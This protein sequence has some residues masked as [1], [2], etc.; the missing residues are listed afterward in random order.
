[1][2]KKTF[3]WLPIII[4]VAMVAGLYIGRY[5]HQASMIGP[6]F[7]STHSKIESLLDII[8]SQY[9]D[10]VDS[11]Q[12]VEDVMPKIIGELD[13]HSA[14]IPAKDLESVN[15]EL[16]GS[17]GGIGVQFSI[18]ND[19]ITVVSVISGGP[20]EKVGILP[21]DRIIAVNDTSFVGKEITNEKVMGKLRGPKG[22]QV[23]LSIKRA[24]SKTPLE[25]D[26][27]RG[28]IPV[29]SVDVS[30]KINEKTGYLKI[31][32]FGRT[33]YDEFMNAL[34]KLKKEGAEKYI[35]DLRGNT[36]GYMEAAINMVN[37][38]L[39]KGQLI[40][41]TEGKA[42][43][44]EEA[45]SNGTGAFQKNQ[46]IILMDEW[47]ASASEIFA[48]AI[49]DN[50]RGLIVGR[51]SFGKGLVQQQIPFSD[52]SAIRLTIA[53][54]YTPS[55]RSIQKNYELGKNDDYSQDIMNRF[56]HGEFDS[57]DSIKLNTELRYK[58][59]N[60]R[61]VY[62]GGGIMPDIF[63]PRDTIGITSYF[64]NV[65]NTGLIYQ[66]AFKY[67]DEHRETL[68]KYKNYQDI[69]RYM[70]KQPLLNEFVA[71]AATHGVKP[72]PVYIN[73]SRHLIT[74]QLYAYIA[75]NILGDEAFYPILMTHDN[76]LL[77]AVEIL[78]DN[79]GFPVLPVDR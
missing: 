18:L 14:Y 11:K 4:A 40:V 37:E 2:N 7:F 28:D 71:Y 31:S 17:F 62:G 42:F 21:G 51:R 27:V 39:P 56:L 45:Y 8:N 67:S 22:S 33:T 72:R 6:G 66:F 24:S 54:Y 60:G 9:V 32:K 38:F 29:N 41:Y 15:E 26:V 58:T 34:A 63:V 59:L 47:S 30:F 44:R 3:I 19:T 55:G 49:Q 25:F 64:N 13:P 76:T 69:L 35:I 74:N 10:T 61:D 53:R 23:N 43:K 52:G 48:G 12:L 73:I 1:M 46:V 36:G 75:R 68:E 78:N 70:Q 16:E 50:D 57:K 79:K 5:Y 65:V 77:K 20:S